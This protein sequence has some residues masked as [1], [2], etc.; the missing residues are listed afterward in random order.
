MKSI[1]VTDA[2]KCQG[3]NRC[4]RVCPVS[5]A[6][7]AYLDH[8]QVKV[9]I[10]ERKCIACG[11][12]LQ[13]CQHEAR[14]F[15]DDTERFF[16]DLSHGEKISIIVAP[17]FKANFRN[18]SSI[19]AWLKKKGVSI[20]A[21]VSFGAD[22]CTWAHI[23][24]IQQQHPRTLITQPCPAIV[25]YIEKY[26]PALLDKLSP[27][28][29][30]M[31]CTAV[32]IKDYMK[33]PGKIAA[34]SPCV[35][36]SN[37]FEETQLVQYNV[38]FKRLAQYIE[39]HRIIIPDASFEFDHITSSLGRVYSMPGG[40]KENVEH[41]LGKKI[42]VD[43]SEGQ[44]VV[45]KNLDLFAEER[46]ENLP[47][48]FDVLNCAEGCN[49][50]TG[51]NHEQSIFN[52]NQV[53]DTQ[54]QT[55][56][57]TY[58]K[59][60][61][62]EMDALFADFDS[63]FKVTS[64]IRRYQKKPVSE[65]TYTDEAVEDAFM[66]LGKQTEEQRTHNCYA[67]GNETCR[68]MAICIA[69][70]IS[71]PENCMEKSRQD[72][73]REHEAFINE[74]QDSTEKISHISAEVEEIGKLFAGVLS[75]VSGMSD[76]IEQY[77]KMTKLINDIALQTQILS[78]NASIEASN[79]GAAG[80]GFAVI[81]QAIRELAAKSQQATGDIGKTSSGAQNTIS[82]IVKASDEV[83]K[84]IRTVS[85]YIEEITASISGTN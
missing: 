48:L 47:V 49:V 10:D 11:A 80:K 9:R 56:L 1:I 76:T 66:K 14:S 36:K 63:R 69:K 4:L 2:Q 43:K 72:I 32:Y 51:C 42:R 71:I 85:S 33:V 41:Y 25:G 26:H 53:M 35:A 77:N 21:D 68:D 46:E 74:R 8:G 55:A 64:F 5:E 54:R 70:G 81:S 20:I 15:A 73:L 34:L 67:C 45:Y 82:N 7:V 31:L 39:D 84:S 60:S 75:G 18:W 50:G 27:V 61:A 16:A 30:P 38:T 22:I 19:L 3:C 65:I 29:S 62:D 59:A 6:N 57:E 23:R 83:D 78:I 13:A 52:I 24:Y 44:S 28:H 58:P 12:C 37:E 40:L 79:A 17:A